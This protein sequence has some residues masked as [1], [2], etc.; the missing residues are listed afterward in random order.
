MLK[1]RQDSLLLLSLGSVLLVLAGAAIAHFNALGMIDFKEFYLSGKCLIEHRDPYQESQLWELYKREAGELPSALGSV[2][3]ATHGHR[4][5]NFPLP[6]RFC[7][8]RSPMRFGSFS[9]RQLLFSLHS[10]F[11]RPV[12]N[13]RRASPRD[14]FSSFS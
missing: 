14:W 8:S 7:P 11:G 12:L 3:I 13:F 6:L 10:Q 1:E 4:S 5:P 9:A 2:L